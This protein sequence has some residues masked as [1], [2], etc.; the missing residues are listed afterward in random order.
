[1][2]ECKTISYKSPPFQSNNLTRFIKPAVDQNVLSLFY[3]SEKLNQ[4]HIF[5]RNF[6][7]TNVVNSEDVSLTSGDYSVIKDWPLVV[8][9]SRNLIYFLANCVTPIIVSL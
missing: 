6:E 8:D 3:G 1:M 9:T 7:L 2:A 5:L 4:C